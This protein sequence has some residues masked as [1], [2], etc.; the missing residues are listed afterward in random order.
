M[1][2][3]SVL[4]VFYL[5]FVSITVYCRPTDSL[6]VELRGGKKFIIHRVVKGE[7]LTM[8]AARY[9][10]EEGEIINSNA[11]ITGGVFLGQII[12]IPLNIEKYGDVE[13]KPIAPITDSRLPLAKTLPA[14][15]STKPS[16]NKIIEKTEDEKTEKPV[17]V[18]PAEPKKDI[19]LAA[20]PVPKKE[21]VAVKNP[22]PAQ[23][24]VVKVDTPK[25]EI[26]K[27]VPKYRTY[28]VASVQTVSQLAETFEVD[29]KEIIELNHLKVYR[30]K[31]GQIVKVPV[32]G[33]PVIAKAEPVPAPEPPAK[34]VAEPLVKFEAPQIAMRIKP[35]VVQTLIVKDTTKVLANIESV[36]PAKKDTANLL[37][38]VDS[39]FTSKRDSLKLASKPLK[40]LPPAVL[41]NPYLG[42]K[43][44]VVFEIPNLE[45]KADSLKADSII[46]SRFKTLSQFVNEPDSAIDKFDFLYRHPN[47][48]A[49]KVSE[50][51]GKYSYYDVWG[52]K[53]ANANAVD[54]TSIQ[55]TEGAGDEYYT[56]VVKNGE[57]IESIAKKYNVSSSDIINW[58]Q[59]VKYRLRVGRDLIVNVERAKLDYLKRAIP[60]SAPKGEGTIIK[61]EIEIGLGYYNADL[62]LHGVY[63]NNVPKG[64]FIYILNRDNFE[65]Y[66]G[67]VDG[68]LPKNAPPKTVIQVDKR[69]AD[70]L[71]IDKSIFN[72]EVWYGLAE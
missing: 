49:Y 34:I 31:V 62:N 36:P 20:P 32:E 35:P 23:A 11:L 33:Q 57:T 19:V 9:G 70:K 45:T 66:F 10:L 47:S 72:I 69:I 14:P 53:A 17:I 38:R 67:R 63:C 52:M 30:L 26:P 28:V 4:I 43:G 48:V 68:P 54:V 6:R 39:A 2:K 25:K 50:V 5:V 7:S 12:K 18:D 46:R 60:K 41:V 42:V 65:E 21:P 51:G 59:I 58:N 3:K 64:K 61:E 24:P 44:F 15:P 16:A 13:A 56:H 8:L 71:K 55:Q 22:V 27:S 1:T 29:P 37:A 40:P